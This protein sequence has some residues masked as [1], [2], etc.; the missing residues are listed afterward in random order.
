MSENGP[1]SMKE[2]W[3][4]TL[5]DPIT[6]PDGEVVKVLHFPRMKGKYL[7]KFRMRI[8]QADVERARAGE[9]VGSTMNFSYDDY[10]VIGAAML[11]DS[12]LGRVS[13]AAV[14]DEMGAEDVH[15]V[16][17][18]LGERFAGGQKTGKEK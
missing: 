11:A 9:E 6:L 15:E 3:D 4:Y 8:E 17:G 7:R 18:K 10:M 5:I 13:A 14:F 2:A 16:I 1:E 12:D